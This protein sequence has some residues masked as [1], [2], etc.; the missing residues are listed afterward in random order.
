MHWL[1]RNGNPKWDGIETYDDVMGILQDEPDLMQEVTVATNLLKLH[2][3]A[4]SD[5]HLVS[6]P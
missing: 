5:L 1:L 6:L 3:E 4:C 2:K